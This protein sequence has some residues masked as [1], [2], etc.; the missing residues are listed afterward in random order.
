MQRFIQRVF[1][2]IFIIITIVVID[3]GLQNYLLF[4]DEDLKLP[5][6][7]NSLILGHSHSAFAYND[8]YINNTLN[9]SELGEAYIYTYFKSKKII[10]SNPQIKRV[11]IEFTNNQIYKKDMNTWMWGDAQLQY[12]IKRY[13]VILDKEALQILYDKNATGLINAFSK[14]LF[15]N[16]VRFFYDNK[17]I[18][19]H[20][21][22]GRYTPSVKILK[23]TSPNKKRKHLKDISEYNIVYLQ[24]IIKYCQDRNIQ[25]CLV[26]SPMHKNFDISFSENKFKTILHTKFK[27]VV[28]LDNKNFP[29]SDKSFQDLEHLN[30]SGSKIYSQYFNNQINK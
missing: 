13:G 5:K 4:K 18:V 16:L 3:L 8:K 14:S 25:V 10:E 22:M 6:E 21:G 11:Y 17:D 12:R 30:S 26:R 23:E 27:N 19:L 24:K 15:D 7:Y 2:F 9:L 28:W 1:I 20:G 29:L